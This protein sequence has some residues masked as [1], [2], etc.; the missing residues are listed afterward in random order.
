MT[1]TLSIIIILVGLLQVKAQS[2]YKVKAKK[3]DGIFSML[4]KEG[5]NP[6][7]YYAQFIELN[8]DNLRNG[9]E[10]HLG[11]EYFIPNVDDSFKKT[12]IH[13]DADKKMEA[14]IFER[15]LPEITAKSSRLKN[16]VIYLISGNA[17]LNTTETTKQITDEITQ[18]LAKE[19]MVHGAQVYFIKSE[20]IQYPIATEDESTTEGAMADLQQMQE[21]VET[22]NKKYLIHQG[23][24]QRLLVTRVNNAITTNDYCDVSVYHHNKSEEG[25]KIAENLERL[26][27]QNSVQNKSFKDYDEVFTDK[28][29]LYLAKNALPAI[30]LIDIGGESDVAETMKIKSDKQ[31]LTNLIASGILNDYADLD[32][33]E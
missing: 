2:T 25:K 7:K 22:I 5:L 28:N 18:N 29:N 16:A 1:K 19:L 27:S 10:L 32:I 15:E 17:V 9:S 13:V 14:S 4:R 31:L 24:Y 33:E 11:R 30:T 12:A 8:K 6:S 21:Y 26:F 23:K 3:G 20:A